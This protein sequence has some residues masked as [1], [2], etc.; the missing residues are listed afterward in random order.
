MKKKSALDLL[1][2]LRSF[3]G[4]DYFKKAYFAYFKTFEKRFGF[5]PHT[6]EAK[7]FFENNCFDIKM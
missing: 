2:Q 7:I 3:R 6:T 5:K 4:T 1:N